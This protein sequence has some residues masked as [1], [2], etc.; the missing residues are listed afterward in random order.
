[1]LRKI[2]LSIFAIAVCAMPATAAD[3]AAHSRLG[4]LF[5]EKAEP[6]AEQRSDFVF[7]YAPQVDI[8][9]FV[10][11]YYGKINSYHYAP[12][13]GGTSYLMRLPYACG[14]HGYC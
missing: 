14:W 3:L 4:A 8:P 5:V 1:M 13:Y 10:G 12:Y 2:L 6:R 11:G 9:P 7:L